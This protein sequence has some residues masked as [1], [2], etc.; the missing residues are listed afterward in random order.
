MVSLDGAELNT[1]RVRSGHGSLLA[2]DRLGFA[3]TPNEVIQLSAVR[4]L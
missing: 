4:T 1:A 3:G 2:S